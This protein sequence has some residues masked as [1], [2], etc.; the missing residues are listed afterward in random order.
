M[1]ANNVIEIDDWEIF[2]KLEKFIGVVILG[3]VHQHYFCTVLQF[4]TLS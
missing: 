4:L 1:V 2:F 3:Y